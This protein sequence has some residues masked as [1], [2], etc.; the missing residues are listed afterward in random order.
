MD[1]FYYLFFIIAKSN[2]APE[3]TPQLKTSQIIPITLKIYHKLT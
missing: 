2:T 3:Y 1:Y